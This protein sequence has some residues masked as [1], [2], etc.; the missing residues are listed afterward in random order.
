MLFRVEMFLGYISTS[1]R[2]ENKN[3]STRAEIKSIICGIFIPHD[4]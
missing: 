3:I 1:V 2:V 4:L